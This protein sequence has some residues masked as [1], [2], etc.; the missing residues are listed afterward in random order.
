[1]WEKGPKAIFCENS[2]PGLC[3][4][5]K[6]SCFGPFRSLRGPC[7]S[8][9]MCRFQKLKGKNPYFALHFKKGRVQALKCYF[10]EKFHSFIQIRTH[11]S[12]IHAIFMD[13]WARSVPKIA[14]FENFG[15]KNHFSRQI[16]S[17]KFWN[18]PPT[19]LFCTILHKKLLQS[20]EGQHGGLS[21]NRTFKVRNDEHFLK[22]LTYVQE[23]Y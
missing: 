17:S 2:C 16:S 20:F 12:G 23:P 10:I 3:K 8:P 14:L 15:T 11:S 9:T 22:I 18:K 19:F 13:F 1:M 21:K 7:Q 4:N 5:A 6:Y